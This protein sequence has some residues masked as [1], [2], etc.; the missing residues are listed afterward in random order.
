WGPSRLRTWIR[1]TTR[2]RSSNPASSRRNGQPVIPG[3]PSAEQIENSAL[4][5]RQPCGFLVVSRANRFTGEVR[6]EHGRMDV[7]LPADRPRVAKRLLHLIDGG[8]DVF[9]ARGR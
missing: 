9:L 6:L 4:V 5:R 2:E 1:K 8:D 7:A 3:V